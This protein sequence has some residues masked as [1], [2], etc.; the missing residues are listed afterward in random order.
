MGHRGRKRAKVWHPELI[1]A[2]VRMRGESLTS[3]ARLNR[4]QEDACRDALRTRRPKAE[5]A[6][7]KFIGVPV[8]ELWPDRYA[9][10]STDVDSASDP[11][12][13]RQMAERV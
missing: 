7:A 5:A 6:I 9:T 8:E 12:A 4:L 11:A 10:S 3:L 2:E 1:K 13:H